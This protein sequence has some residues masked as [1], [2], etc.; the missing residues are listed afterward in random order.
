MGDSIIKG[1]GKGFKKLGGETV[2][3]LVDESHKILD[4]TI[5]GKELLGLGGET[6]TEK[7]MVEKSATVEALN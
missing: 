5:T 6:M 7:E 4:S 1:V 3:K 2:E